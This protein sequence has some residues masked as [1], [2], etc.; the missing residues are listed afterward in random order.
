MANGSAVRRTQGQI[1]LERS[2]TRQLT[3]DRFVLDRGAGVDARVGQ[4][5]AILILDAF[6]QHYPRPPAPAWQAVV[7]QRLEKLR[8]LTAGWD[9]YRAPALNQDVFWFAAELLDKIMQPQTSPPQ[10]VPSSVGGVQIEWH[11]KD[12][13][14]EIHIVAPYHCTIWY[15]DHRSGKVLDEEFTADFSILTAPVA[16]LSA[17]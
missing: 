12:I 11:E 16:A 7:G 9:G 2:G 15:E 13:D 8:A 5:A 17:R 1:I 4:G 14:L 10:V 3:D 6:V